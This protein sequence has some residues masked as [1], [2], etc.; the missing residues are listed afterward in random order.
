MA[1]KKKHVQT[2]Q[3]IRSG[4][5]THGSTTKAGKVRSQTPKIPKQEHPPRK[6]PR[7]NNRR[8]YL[9]YLFKRT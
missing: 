8:K 4:R 3:R 6:G 2:G 5:G 1:K 7:I 9:K